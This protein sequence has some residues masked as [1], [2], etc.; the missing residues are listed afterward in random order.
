M[1]NKLFEEGIRTER[2][3][4]LM[5]IDEMNGFNCGYLERGDNSCDMIDPDELKK[6]IKRGKE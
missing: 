5:I 6:L 4:I 2:E 3:R 1:A